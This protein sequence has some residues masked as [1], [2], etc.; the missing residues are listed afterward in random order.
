[1]G[2]RIN[3]HKKHIRPLWVSKKEQVEGL[4]KCKFATRLGE[5]RLRSHSGGDDLAREVDIA[6]SKAWGRYGL[7]SRTPNQWEGGTGDRTP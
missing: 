6:A 7:R 5:H 1:M 2:R 4:N 3:I